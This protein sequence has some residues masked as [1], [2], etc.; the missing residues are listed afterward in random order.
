MTVDLAGNRI[1]CDCA[2]AAELGTVDAVLEMIGAG[3][4]NGSEATGADLIT[5]RWRR[6]DCSEPVEHAGLSVGTF[7]DRIAPTV[8]RYRNELRLQVHRFDLSWICRTTRCGLVVRQFFAPN[9]QYLNVA[10]CSGFVVGVAICRTTTNPQQIEPV[11]FEP[12][13]DIMLDSTHRAHFLSP[14]GRRAERSGGRPRG[15]F[16]LSQSLLRFIG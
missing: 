15:V 6:L 16:Y 4:G 13:Q 9:P 14:D 8:R 1:H 11:E 12:V 2:L 3:G 10:M 7:V 5:R